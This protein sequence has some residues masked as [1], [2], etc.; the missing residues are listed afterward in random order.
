M[1]CAAAPLVSWSI[2][3]LAGCTTTVHHVRMDTARL[4]AS[5]AQD[6]K[7]ACA[8][9]IGRLEDARSSR[10]TAGGLGIHA[11]DFPDVIQV[12]RTQLGAAGLSEAGGAAVDIRVLHLYL[13]QSGPTKVP[14]AVYQVRIDQAPAWLVRSQPASSNWLGSENEAYRAYRAAMDG[15]MS[16]VLDYL[17]AHC[18][19]A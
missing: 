6:R 7:V 11:F 2:L 4:S 16:R 19:S 12:L 8:Y 1:R 9:R 18:R 15:A 5:L 13:S 10:V 17:D 14:V 3:L